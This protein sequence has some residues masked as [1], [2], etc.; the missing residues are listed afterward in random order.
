MEMSAQVSTELEVYVAEEVCDELALQA[1]G[2]LAS[3]K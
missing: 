1:E 3:A 2:K